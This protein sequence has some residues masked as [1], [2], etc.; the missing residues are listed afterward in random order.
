MFRYY[1]FFKVIKLEE[2]V[3]CV[4][5]TRFP[6]VGYPESIGDKKHAE[7][8]YAEQIMFIPYSEYKSMKKT[9]YISAF[10]SRKD[11]EWN[12]NFYIKKGCCICLNLKEMKLF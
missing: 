5:D 2:N 4:I 11:D 1:E 12:V 10:K 8:Y 3:Y 7:R 9:G 6:K